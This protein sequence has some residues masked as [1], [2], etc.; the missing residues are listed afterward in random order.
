MPEPIPSD[1]MEVQGNGTGRRSFHSV[2]S[3]TGRSD[4]DADADAETEAGTRVPAL[5]L[6]G[7]EALVVTGKEVRKATGSGHR[8]LT[9]A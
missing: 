8:R 6:T 7:K 4:A 5:V 3:A 1:V 2:P 9:P